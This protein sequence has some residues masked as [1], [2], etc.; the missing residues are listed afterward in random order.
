MHKQDIIRLE[1]RFF[2]RLTKVIYFFCF[3]IYFLIIA[4]IL[5]ISIPNANIADEKKTYILCDNGKKSLTINKTNLDFYIYSGILSDSS[6]IEAK[7]FCMSKETYDQMSFFEK[8][9]YNAGVINKNYNLKILYKPRDWISYLLTIFKVAMSF[10]FFYIIL[11]T[12]KETLLYLAFNKK[13]NWQG[14]VRLSFKHFV[15]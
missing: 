4:I 1:N 7:K 9:L 15:D 14:L 10:I 6:D 13:F 11:N 2:Y 5:F 3:V 12:I 8:E